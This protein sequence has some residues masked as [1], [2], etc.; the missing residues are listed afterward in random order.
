[1][2]R[3]LAAPII[4]LVM[5]MICIAPAWA[6]DSLVLSQ[7][8]LGNIFLSTEAVQIP[9]QTTGDSV[10]WTV[11][12][13][14]GVQVAAAVT[15]VP[16]NGQ[17]TIAPGLGRLGYFEIHATA[18]RGG[19]AVASADTAFA[20]VM[21]SNVAGM[22]DS[23]FGVMT[24][25]AHGWT[26]DVMQVLA[27]GASPNFVTSSIGRTWSPRSRPRRPTRLPPTSLTWPPLQE[28]A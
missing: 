5:L 9:L 10:S 7:A 27:R 19:T 14:S 23:P 26:P 11:K 22:H 2:I 21:A 4:F 18:M 17:A 24:H 3:R 15:P 1:M 6:V 13:F 25:F 12:D 8:R 28:P 16:G 20:V